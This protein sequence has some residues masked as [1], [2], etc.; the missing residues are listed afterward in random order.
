MPISFVPF[1]NGKLWTGYDWRIDKDDELAELVALVALGQYR[2]V[3][4]ILAKTGCGEVTTV[5]TALAGARELLTVSPSAD[6]YHRD[7][8]LFQV[9]AWIAA[10][11]Q[12]EAS[13]IR[14]PH[15]Q[16][17]EKGFD[18]IHVH[19]DRESR[20][21]QFV[22]ICEEKA[23]SQPRKVIRD[24]VWKEFE[25]L[26]TGKR[27][28]KI[29][30]ELV[31]LLE[32]RSDLDPDQAIEKILWAEARAYRIAITANT[33]YRSKSTRKQLFKGYDEIVS[34]CVSRRRAEVLHL[35]DL[36]TWMRCIAGKALTAAE[37]IATAHV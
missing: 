1:K 15:M 13:L 35:D 28:N 3:Q 6:P 23:T 37:R 25:L 12:N 10:R 14:P 33:S 27:D 7:G 9:M 16:H 19:I 4:R 22:V 21:V 5:Q 29:L 34:G 31:T 8:W 26:E 2:H 17:A 24:G 36:R 18:G 11:I 32:T 20:A 30:A